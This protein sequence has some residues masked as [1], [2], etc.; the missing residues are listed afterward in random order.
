MRCAGYQPALPWVFGWGLVNP[1]NHESFE[2]IGEPLGG[3]NVLWAL[4]FHLAHGYG[5]TPPSVI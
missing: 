3:K 4:I 2:S 5:V 1:P